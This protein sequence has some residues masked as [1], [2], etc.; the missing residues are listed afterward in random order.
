MKK[1]SSFFLPETM[2]ESDSRD[3]AWQVHK[4]YTNYEI[5]TITLML[6]NI[7][8]KR[9]LSIQVNSDSYQRVYIN[10]RCE[11]YHRVIAL[12]FIPNPDPEKYTEVNHKNHIRNDNRIEN[13]EWC[14]ISDNRKDRLPYTQQKKRVV[15]ELPEGCLL[16]TK[17]KD[18]SF[19]DYYYNPQTKEILK[20]TKKGFQIISLKG[21]KFKL[22]DINKVQHLFGHQKFVKTFQA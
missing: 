4:V 12:H 10:G 9:V 20:K 19:D 2:T 22:T 11:S 7:K 21:K 18:F 13:L 15:K 1:T 6:R 17:Y 3:E 14:T 5:N 16:I 8:T